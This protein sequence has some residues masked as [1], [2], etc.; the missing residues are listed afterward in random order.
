MKSPSDLQP[1]IAIQQTS[2]VRLDVP[3]DLAAL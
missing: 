1:E 2:V 3:L